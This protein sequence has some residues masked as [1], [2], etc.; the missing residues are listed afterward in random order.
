MDKQEQIRHAFD[1]V[2]GYGNLAVIEAIFA[3]DY[4]AHAGDKL[5]KGHD[6]IKRWT[7][8]LRAAIPNIKA[9]KIEF[10]NEEG[11]II[12][13]QRTLSGIHKKNM[14]GIPPSEKKITWVEMVVSRFEGN[15]IAEEWVV[16]ELASQL[17]LKQPKKKRLE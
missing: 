3:A 8:Q 10:L 4:I 16:S 2:I 13:W 12:T 5:Y 7:K 15:K 17:L 1:Q 9:L 14:K 6:F 11:E